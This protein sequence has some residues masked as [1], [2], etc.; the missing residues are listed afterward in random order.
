M[1]RRA[2]GI[3]TS[4]KIWLGFNPSERAASVCPNDTAWM[5]ALTTSAINEAVY[6]DKAKVRATNSGINLM[7]PL[8]LKPLSSG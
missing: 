3:I 4:L 5:P 2:W 7:P 1:T 6:I 8:K